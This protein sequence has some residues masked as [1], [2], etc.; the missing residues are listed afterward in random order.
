M[1]RV[2]LVGSVVWLAFGITLAGC[3]SGSDA[4]AAKRNPQE[5]GAEIGECYCKMMDELS[6]AVGE[7]AEPAALAPQVEQLK[8]KYVA[9]LVELGRQREVLAPNDRE[10]C[11]R[12]ARTRMMQVSDE[13]L[14]SVEAAQSACKEQDPELAKRLEELR[15]ITRYASF[16]QLRSQLPEEAHRLGID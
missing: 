3:K 12:T 5:L 1:A 10:A 15:R 2:C 16:E 8:Q 6:A 13:Q 4:A 14:E 9:Q 11:D 7:A